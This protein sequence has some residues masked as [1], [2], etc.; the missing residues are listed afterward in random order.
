[1]FT[2]FRKSHPQ[3]LSSNSRPIPMEWQDYIT[4]RMKSPYTDSDL[5]E[6]FF[7]YQYLFADYTISPREWLDAMRVTSLQQ[8]VRYSVRKTAEHQ[9]TKLS[10][11]A[12]LREIDL[13][14]ICDHARIV[15]GIGNPQKD[16]DRVWEMLCLSHAEPWLQIDG[17]HSYFD[18]IHTP[19]PNAMDL[20][21]AARIVQIDPT[22]QATIVHAIMHQPSNRDIK[23]MLYV[24]LHALPR[25]AKIHALQKKGVRSQP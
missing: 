20:I 2:L 18:R 7:D 4:Q 9:G 12:S 14:R 10:D 11:Y 21:L 3:A 22:Q 23:T 19:M 5:L 1:M 17:D 8:D 6:D 16:Y 25:Y 15:L 13:L 24:R